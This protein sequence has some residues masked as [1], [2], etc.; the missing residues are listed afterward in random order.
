MRYKL[1]HF[2]FS[3]DEKRNKAQF[4]IENDLDK[5]MANLKDWPEVDN[6]L[7]QIFN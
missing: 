5:K 2:L 7:N 3:I 6:I 1:F 4:I